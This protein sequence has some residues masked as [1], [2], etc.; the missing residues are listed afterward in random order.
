MAE[1]L[2]ENTESSGF[3]CV[4]LSGSKP[5]ELSESENAEPN[6]FV[7]IRLSGSKPAELRE[8][9][10]SNK[11]PAEIVEPKKQAEPIDFSPSEGRLTVYELNTDPAAVPPAKKGPIDLTPPENR[12][13]VPELSIGSAEVALA[14]KGPIDLTPP[15]NRLAVSE[16]NTAPTAVSPAKN[17]PEEI[18]APDHSRAKNARSKKRI[19]FIE[20]VSVL[21][22]AAA[23]F[24]L[25]LGGRQGIKA[26]QEAYERSKEA[27]SEVVYQAFYDKS[28]DV[29]EKNYHVLNRAVISLSEIRET[30]ELEVLSVSDIVYIIK[31]ADQI[32]DTQNWLQVPG[33][34][35]F[36]LD[37]S[38]GEFLVDNE[39]N[40]V[41]VRL[42]RPELSAD[43][44]SIDYANVKV[45]KME[46]HALT[47]S[48]RDGEELARQQLNEARTKI[49]EDIMS[50]LQY[51]EFAEESA[52]SLMETWIR[53]V[54]KDIADLTVEIEFY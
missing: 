48:A 21:F 42:P 36:T 5:E 31:E 49:R 37:L 22:V 43:N 38:A 40:S 45:L 7:C 28:Y 16:P 50:N 46:S 29:A 33:T 51:N 2:H 44:I 13:A 20:L 23:I 39:R 15:E 14:E 11:T 26:V 12:L 10:E 27:T 18:A 17:E 25:V 6:G 3:E 47:S 53:A 8:N 4:R 24:L 41:Y 54:N 30:A 32:W 1:E 19:P 9:I 35:V 52:R 34:G